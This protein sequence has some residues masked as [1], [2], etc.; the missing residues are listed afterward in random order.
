MSPGSSGFLIGG[1]ADWSC[2]PLV[3]GA[4]SCGPGGPL[5]QPP[6]VRP[7]WLSSGD[8]V[9]FQ[10]LYQGLTNLGYIFSW[11]DVSRSFP[12]EFQG[13]WPMLCC[14]LKVAQVVRV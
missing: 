7:E 9:A 12:S 8:P 4:T 10:R 2:L 1:P 5:V 14:R 6:P 13:P 3:L 11:N